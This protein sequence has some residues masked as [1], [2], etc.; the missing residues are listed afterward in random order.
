MGPED[1]PYS[2]GVFFLNIHFPADYPFK[3]PKVRGPRPARFRAA[4]RGRPRAAGELHD[5]DLPL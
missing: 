1:S 5:A 2:G 4:R 3:P